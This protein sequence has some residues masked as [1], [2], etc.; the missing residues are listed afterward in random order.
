[1]GYDVNKPSFEWK[2][3]VAAELN[4]AI[5]YSFQVKLMASLS[6]T[7]IWFY[8]IVSVRHTNMRR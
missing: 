5:N 1:M 4:I 3:S 6:D 2:D 7:D 8:S